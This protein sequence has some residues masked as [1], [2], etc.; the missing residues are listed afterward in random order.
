VLLASSILGVGEL[1]EPV[2]QDLG[3]DRRVICQVAGT[4]AQ[5]ERVTAPRRHDG[6]S[7]VSGRAGGPLGNQAHDRATVPDISA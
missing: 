5:L 2:V 3:G 1:D 4:Q 7:P 6:A